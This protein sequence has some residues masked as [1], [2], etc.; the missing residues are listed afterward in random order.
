MKDGIVI[1]GKRI[2]RL[3][4]GAVK[5]DRQ[6]LLDS[7]LQWFG[8]FGTVVRT[9]HRC[10]APGCKGELVHVYE[11]TEVQGKP[12]KTCFTQTNNGRKRTSSK[13]YDSCTV[14]SCK[15]WGEF[16]IELLD[17]HEEQAK[18]YRKQSRTW[19]F[20]NDRRRKRS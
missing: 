20:R 18:A 13:V 9:G 3:K 15:M 10:D 11:T 5:V 17:Q 7:V 2:E 16:T 4:G 8:P 14:P 1:P 19:K 12:H 6:W